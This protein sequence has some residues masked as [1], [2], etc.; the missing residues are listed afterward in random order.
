M[1]FRVV[2]SVVA[3]IASGI[4]TF[5]FPTAVGAGNIKMRA[6]LFAKFCRSRIQVFAFSTQDTCGRIL[7][8]LVVIMVSQIFHYFPETQFLFLRPALVQS[9]QAR[10]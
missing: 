10:L 2:Q 1:E 5:I 3:V 8:L 6:T 7:R 4:D 9:C